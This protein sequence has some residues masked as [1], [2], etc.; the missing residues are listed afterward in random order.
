MELLG[1][2]SGKIQE[3]YGLTINYVNPTVPVSM[4][5]EIE[6]DFLIY[7]NPEAD[8][9]M[10]FHKD[11][12]KTQPQGPYMVRI[13]PS[14]P[15]YDERVQN[16]ID[17]VNGDLL[18][19]KIWF[20]P[21]F[22][23]KEDDLEIEVTIKHFPGCEHPVYDT[24]IFSERYGTVYTYEVI[25]EY[26]RIDKKFKIAKAIID[27]NWPRPEPKAEPEPKLK[28]VGNLMDKFR[29]AFYWFF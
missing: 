6:A 17:R 12:I 8:D 13:L 2:L 1:E 24:N 22:T 18:N 10:C 27:E 3:H 29:K 26:A 25:C 20:D 28:S 19:G 11:D 5:K 7:E 9:I 21:C 23:K 4:V 14:N 15:E 16:L